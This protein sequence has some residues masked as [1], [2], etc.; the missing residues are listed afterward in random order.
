MKRV[1]YFALA[2]A[3]FA[4]VASAQFLPPV[5]G[6]EKDSTTG[7]IKKFD[8]SLPLTGISDPGILLSHFTQRPLLIIY[9]SPKCPHCQAAYPKF[10]ELAKAYEPKGVQGLAV[11]IGMVKKNDIRMFMDQLN[12]QLPVFQDANGKFSTAYGSGHVPL[13][14]LVFENGQYIRYTEN[15][16]DTFDQIKAELDKKFSPKPAAAATATA[17]KK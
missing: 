3:L 1:L 2:I 17:K 16:P 8:Y 11:S 4:S 9:F 6:I 13:F 10:Q 5:P 7:A 14:M 15:G 12:V